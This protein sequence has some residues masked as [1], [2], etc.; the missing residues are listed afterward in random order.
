MKKVRVIEYFGTVERTAKACGISRMAV[1]NW[2]DVVHLP[3]AFA[4]E[5]FTKGRLKVNL[6]D[7]QAHYAAETQEKLAKMSTPPKYAPKPYRPTG[8]RSEAQAA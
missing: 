3:I 4:L 2:K 1:Y 6:K 5:K 8:K 7:Y